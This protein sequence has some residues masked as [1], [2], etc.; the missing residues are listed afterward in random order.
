MDVHINLYVWRHFNVRVL[1]K[2]SIG[3]REALE[4][5]AVGV[6]ASDPRVK[7]AGPTRRSQESTSEWSRPDPTRPNARDFKPLDPI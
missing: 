7:P 1:S 6:N 3:T 4:Q 5:E 2:R